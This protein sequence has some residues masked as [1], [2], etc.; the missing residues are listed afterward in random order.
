MLVS[1]WTDI[2]L[3]AALGEFEEQGFARLGRVLEPDAAC[4]LAEQANRL[5]LGKDRIPGLFYQHDS[6]TGRYE[7]LE[8]GAGWVGPSLNYRKLEKLE[9][10]PLFGRWIE[11]D[12]FA[13]IAH[14]V[15]GKD[16]TLYRAVLWNKAPRKGMALPWHQDDGAFWGID[17]PPCLQIWTA[18]DP[19]P[20]DA[21]CLEFV[22]GSHR[23]G[24][25]SELGGTVS[26]ERFEAEGAERCAIA[27]PVEAGEALLIHNH[28]W[29]RSGG[30]R[31]AKPR[32]G[33]G[34]SYLRG[35][36]RC[37]RRK[38]TPREFLP[39]FRETAPAP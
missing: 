19:A 4:E 36:T 10:D 18:L 26:A 3:G 29:H 17:Q 31:T 14:A 2:D 23:A 28:V 34:V 22:P 7:D 25:A 21:G 12:L 30:N 33:F 35:D 38:R 37:R 6:K 9:L 1:D 8:F 39:V 13:R 15:L 32:R 16:V 5:M 20:L 24:L 27:V 11:N